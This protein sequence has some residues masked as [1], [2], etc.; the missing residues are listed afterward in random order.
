MKKIRVV[1][2]Q[3][4]G[5]GNPLPYRS[6]ERHDAST[7]QR[8]LVHISTANPSTCFQS[9]ESSSSPK[10][11][12]YYVI[13]VNSIAKP[14]AKEQLYAD[15]KA[16]HIDVAIIGESKLKR[17]HKDSFI[18]IPGY[19]LF[20]RERVG[21]GGGGVAIYAGLSL[22]SNICQVTNDNRLFELLWV[23]SADER[24]VV[25]TAALHNPPKTLYANEDLYDYI[26]RS[27]EELLAREDKK[28]SFTL[29]ENFKTLNFP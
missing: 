20:R 26:K 24:G 10:P 5:E 3:T 1:T 12:S 29:V 19:Q 17:H 28:F 14:N 7:R 4:K 8:N 13:N 16:Y 22:H 2:S 18:A 9:N 25:I 15:L 21:R 6:Y 11:L 27:L 23:R